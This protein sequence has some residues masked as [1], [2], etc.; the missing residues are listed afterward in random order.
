[1]IEREGYV[2]AHA[3]I[4]PAWSVSEARQHAREV[5]SVLR[6][7]DYREFLG[8]MF[9][10]E[11]ARWDGALEGWGRLR[12]IT[13]SFTRM[14]YID[15]SGT[16]DFDETGPPGTQRAGLRPWFE[17]DSP[18]PV[19]GIVVFG[20]WSSLGYHVG[21]RAVGLD[22]GCVWGRSLT[23][24]RLDADSITPYRVRC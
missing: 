1:M 13:N 19:P 17:H 7:A 3:G 5:E 15:D 14:R 4:Y 10:A 6:S 24:V 16:L 18:E 11:P 22:S 2:F 21:R 12:F 20:H 23:A 9:G 8:N